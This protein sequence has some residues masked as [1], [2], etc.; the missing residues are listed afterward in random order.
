MKKVLFLVLIMTQLLFSNSL[1]L[2]KYG[3]AVDDLS[4]ISKS[5]KIINITQKSLALNTQA[6][7]I[8]NLLSLAVKEKKIGYVE[9]FK[10]YEKFQ[11]ID[12]GDELLLK[13]LQ[14]NSIFEMIK[15]YPQ[16]INYY[17]KY[18]NEF[19][20]ATEKYGVKEV[21][22]YLDDSAKFGKD[23]EVLS[24]L[25]KFGDKANSFFQANWGKLTTIGFV[26]LNADSLIVSAENLG[27][28][29][30]KVVGNTAAKS[31]D[32]IANSNLGLII[33]LALILLVFFKFG[34][35]KI[36]RK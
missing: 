28:A 20:V 12:N 6:N 21:T 16:S 1:S 18:G 9:Q 10:Y 23:K 11:K 25:G 8:K 32:S 36:F 13:V 35:E 24:L 5:V 29:S 7:N 4:N 2:L 14:N 3:T 22:N 31:V 26:G 30:V 17:S 15:K 34:F 19:I 27:V 33:G